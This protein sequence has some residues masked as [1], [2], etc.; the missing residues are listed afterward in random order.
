MTQS[1]DHLNGRTKSN[2][3]TRP[4]FLRLQNGV[5]ESLQVWRKLS[6]TFVTCIDFYKYT[7]PYLHWKKIVYFAYRK[8]FHQVESRLQAAAFLQSQHRNSNLSRCDRQPFCLPIRPHRTE[9][10]GYEGS[11]LLVATQGQLKNSRFTN[12][13]QVRDISQ[14]S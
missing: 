1:L 7:C 13:T 2:L 11:E 12:E 3:N 5:V 6:I 9:C 10:S 14:E 4:D 8:Y